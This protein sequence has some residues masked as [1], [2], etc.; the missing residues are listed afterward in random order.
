MY[1]F[2]G[3]GIDVGNVA[4]NRPGQWRGTNI[5]GWALIVTRERLRQQY[6]SQPGIVPSTSSS[7]AGGSTAL[8]TALDGEGGAAVEEK[9]DGMAVDEEETPE[10]RGKGGGG[11]GGGRKRK[12]KCSGR[13]QNDWLQPE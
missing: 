1:S 2:T 5:L 3:T 12:G 8:G 13:L 10:S 7:I 9:E 4:E 6:V 11:K